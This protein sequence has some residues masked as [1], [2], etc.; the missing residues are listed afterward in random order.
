M[1]LF[2]AMMLAS[3]LNGDFESGQGADIPHW[4]LSG[5]A[6]KMWRVEPG[7]G[8]NGNRGLVWE[9]AHTNI[10]AFPTQRIELKPGRRY[11]ISAQVKTN[12]RKIGSGSYGAGVFLEWFDKDGKGL[13]SCYPPRARGSNDWVTIENVTKK[14][15]DGDVAYGVVGAFVHKGCV[16]YAAFDDIEV[17]EYAVKPLGGLHSSAYRDTAK[18]GRI[19]FFAP[20]FVDTNGFRSA[21]WKVEFRYLAADGARRAVAAESVTPEFVSLSLD[22]AELAMGRQR[23]ECGV[24]S[25]DGRTRDSAELEFTRV[26]ELPKRKVYVDSRRR[27][28]VDGKPFFPLGLYSS[29]LRPPVVSAYSK[30]PFNCVMPYHS[31]NLQQL[32]DCEAH[33]I[34]VIYAVNKTYAGWRSAPKGVKTEA[35]EIRWIEGRMA[36]AKDHPAMLAWYLADELA[37]SYVPRL[38]KRRAWLAERDPD[39]PTFACY[40]RFDQMREYLPT[41]DI[42]GTDIYPVPNKA[43]RTVADVTRVTDDGLFRARSLWQVPQA[44]SWAET[45]TS[46]AGGARFPTRAEMRSMCWQMVAA[47]ANGLIGYCLHQCMDRFTGESIGTRWDDVCAVFADLKRFSHVFLCGGEPPPVR[48]VPQSLAVRTFREG[49]D[50]WLLVCNLEDTEVSASFTIEGACGESSVVYGAGARATDGKVEVSMAPFD[51][52]LVQFSLSGKVEVK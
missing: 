12:I 20:L 23:V 37:V 45:H 32:D 10:Y 30:G 3:L 39:H 48:G 13:G 28:I 34:K 24:S 7:A 5:A 9:C 15:I 29:V 17:T 25:A 50:V 22:V 18:D 44:F 21:D 31:P 11:R 38:A 35:D 6:R 36:F 8:V 19:T 40:C 43:L 52:C 26:E 51:V 41:V 49:A 27:L 47:G 33:G 42:F 14:P 46:L 2:F 1:I 16:G 4:K